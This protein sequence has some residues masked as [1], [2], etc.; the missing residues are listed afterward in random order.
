MKG[1][2]RAVNDTQTRDSEYNAVIQ[3]AVFL[4][5]LREE[6]IEIRQIRYVSNISL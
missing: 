6:A 3:P 1:I 2:S 5:D 4:L